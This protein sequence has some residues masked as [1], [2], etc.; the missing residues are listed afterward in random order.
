[1]LAIAAERVPALAA[2][3]PQRPP[4]AA[5]CKPCRGSGR[6]PLMLPW[7]N[8][9]NATAW[10]GSRNTMAHRNVALDRA[11]M[12][13]ARYSAVGKLTVFQRITK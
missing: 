6:L 5:D 11:S 3:L 10:V 4:G 9:R 2:W 8:V 7:F 13:H 1:V 12:V